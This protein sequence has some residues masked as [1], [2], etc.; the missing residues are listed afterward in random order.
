[1]YSAVQQHLT[2]REWGILLN[3]HKRNQGAVQ[4][5]KYYENRQLKILLSFG[6]EFDGHERNAGSSRVHFK[7]KIKLPSLLSPNTLISVWL[8][9]ESQKN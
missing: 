2:S 7:R 6:S 4:V 9:A 3:Q 1:V 8:A 5:I